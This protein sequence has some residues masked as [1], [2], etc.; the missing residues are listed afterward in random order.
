M[1]SRCIYCTR[2]ICDISTVKPNRENR[3]E[4]P[5]KTA[6]QN[7]LCASLPCSLPA[8]RAP[9]RRP[10]SLPAVQQLS[11]AHLRLARRAQVQSST[12]RGPLTQWQAGCKR[13]E[14]QVGT[15][16]EAIPC[17]EQWA[18]PR[19]CMPTV[20]LPSHSGPLG[21][22]P[23]SLRLLFPHLAASTCPPVA[24]GR[25]V[26]T[27]PIPPSFLRRSCPMVPTRRTY[28]EHGRPRGDTSLDQQQ[29]GRGRHGGGGSGTQAAGGTEVPSVAMPDHRC[30][31]VRRPTATR[32]P[33]PPTSL[34]VQASARRL[35][36]C[37][38]VPG[39]CC[40]AAV[41]P[42]VTECDFYCFLR[43][44]RVALLNKHIGLRPVRAHAGNES[45]VID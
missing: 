37:M 44:L 13:A 15:H 19:S 6:R 41:G 45:S 28:G 35:D 11:Q 33:R 27:R 10:G 38:R 43:C 20:A 1:D 3:F 42:F 29:T 30:H 34:K 8:R 2:L 24:S 16:R 21:T 31:R 12:S 25:L 22:P 40:P 9:T 36:N 32:S 14:R 39:T 7:V 4:S 23:S 17:G 5:W 26:D 18:R